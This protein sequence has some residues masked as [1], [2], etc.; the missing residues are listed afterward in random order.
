MASAIPCIGI[1]FSILLLYVGAKLAV[2]RKRGRLFFPLVLFLSILFSLVLWWVL[3]KIPYLRRG[4]GLGV[5]VG[6]IWLVPHMPGLASLAALFFLGK[7]DGCR[8][9]EA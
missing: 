9:L 2:R 5:I 4:Q 7:P 6:L 1:F 8:Q 3:L